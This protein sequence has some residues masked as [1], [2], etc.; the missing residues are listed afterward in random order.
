MVRQGQF[1]PHS[2]VGAVSGRFSQL[3]KLGALSALLRLVLALSHPD[4]CEREPDY[5]MQAHVYDMTLISVEL[6]QGEQ[7][8][9]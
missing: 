3:R 1:C 7:K 6:L 9:T 2:A 5:G 8:K 4:P